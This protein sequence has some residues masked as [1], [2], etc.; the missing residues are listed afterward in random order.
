MNN[1]FVDNVAAGCKMRGYWI[2]L[3]DKYQNQVHPESFMGNSAHSNDHGLI[4]YKR[5]WLPSEPAVFQDFVS[6]NNREGAKFHITGN[7]TFKNA[8]FA[9]NVIGVRYGAWNQGVAFE[10]TLFMLS[11][12]KNGAYVAEITMNNKA[13][14]HKNMLFRNVIFRN[15][16]EKTGTMKFSDHKLMEEDMGDPVH[17]YNVTFENCDENAKPKLSECGYRYR[18]WFLEDYDGTLGPAGTDPGFYI[19]D[20]ELTKVF[21]PED[22]CAA[23]PN[24][25]EGCAAFCEGVCVRLVRL[26]PTGRLTMENTDYEELQLTNAATG[27][28]YVYPLN[29]DGQFMVV[30]PAGQYEGEFLD[31]D[32]ESLAVDTVDVEVFAEPRCTNFVTE[33]DFVF[34][35]TVPPT[36]A[37]T[38]SPS[39]EPTIYYEK[40][41]DLVGQNLYCSSTS[42]FRLFKNTDTNSVE[43]CHE[44]CF[45]MPGCNFFAYLDWKTMCMGCSLEDSSHLEDHGFS[46]QAYEMTSFKDFGYELLDDFDGLNTRCL[47]N[48]EWLGELTTSTR[49]E[50]YQRCRDTPDC[51]WFSWG[52]DQASWT[53]RGDCILCQSDGGLESYEDFNTYEMMSAPFGI[54]SSSPS[55]VPS[56][57]PSERTE[58]SDAPSFFPS[59]LP[60]SSLSDVPSDVPTNV[61][62]NKP[63]VRKCTATEKKRKKFVTRDTGERYTCEYVKSIRPRRRRKEFCK[64]AVKG[65]DGKRRVRTVCPKTCGKVGQGECS[66]LDP[67]K[68]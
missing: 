51:G 38:T 3:D 42:T 41:Y 66:F 5:G 31:Q 11:K 44:R 26:T 59:E 24:G 64:K 12:Q 15:Y 9:D 55:D 7:L 37:P 8:L 28:S 23:T 19:R 68:R 46:F 65:G 30:L 60:S 48:G 52:E 33:D 63:T 6:F 61:P 20:H 47:S 2:E 40:T 50:C 18:N 62:T 54:P 29:E 57:S 27:K 14:F 17:A 45:H 4:T 25:E 10:D 58:P 49:R 21:L 56:L 53:E 16:G 34:L 39:A 67:K 32:G 1:T 43:E 36:D 22:S 13:W 35:N